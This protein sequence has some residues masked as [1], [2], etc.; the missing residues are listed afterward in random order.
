MVNVLLFGSFPQPPKGF[1]LWPDAHGDAEYP[2]VDVI[3][4]R[5]RPCNV[6]T[7]RLKILQDASGS[8][9]DSVGGCWSTYR[10]SE[11]DRTPVFAQQLHG[12]SAPTGS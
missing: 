11:V 12:L 2:P 8:V 3:I 1:T 6:F 4:H 5:H 7:L 9:T 10:I